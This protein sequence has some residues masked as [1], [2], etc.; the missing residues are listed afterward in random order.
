MTQNSNPLQVIGQRA[1]DAGMKWQPGM[2]DT[3]GRFVVVVQFGLPWAWVDGNS[4]V[5]PGPGEN[6]LAWHNRSKSQWKHAVPDLSDTATRS[7]ALEQVQVA[8]GD[9]AIC[10][11]PVSQFG[12]GVY[13]GGPGYGDALIGWAIRIKH[14]K[15]SGVSGITFLGDTPGEALV[16][17]L[18]YILEKKR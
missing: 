6:F 12:E 5:V 9:K 18:E 2:R 8:L 15:F 3:K 7:L 4:L 11:V 13:P 14:H 16:E 1:I 17:A 10:L